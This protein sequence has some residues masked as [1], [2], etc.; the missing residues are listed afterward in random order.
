[1]PGLYDMIIKSDIMENCEAFF[2]KYLEE[3]G[4]PDEGLTDDERDLVGQQVDYLLDMMT[5]IYQEH[6]DDY[7]TVTD[8]IIDK[9]IGM[10]VV[11]KMNE[12][13]LCRLLNE[14]NDKLKDK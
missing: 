7:D 8:T 3:E 4:V 11:A 12:A 10:C 5:D 9:L 14:L 6:P 2:N 1:M 13:R